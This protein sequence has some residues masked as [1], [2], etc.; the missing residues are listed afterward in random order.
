M[1]AF[2]YASLFKKKPIKLARRSI[3]DFILN[4]KI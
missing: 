3:V 4:E 2:L 1:F